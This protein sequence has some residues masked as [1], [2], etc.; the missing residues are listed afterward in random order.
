V[1]LW[2]DQE[3]NPTRSYLTV[4][5]PNES[6]LS[7]EI[8]LVYTVPANFAPPSLNKRVAPRPSPVG[9]KPLPKIGENDYVDLTAVIADPAARQRIAALPNPFHGLA[10]PQ[11]WKISFNRV[12]GVQKPSPGLAG[13]GKLTRDRVALDP[14][15]VLW[16]TNIAN[17]LGMP[18][19]PPPAKPSP[20]VDHTLDPSVLKPH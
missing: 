6:G 5:L 3:P 11:V 9:P 7:G 18:P 4:G 12:V 15:K 13:K 2:K 10:R 20:K 19:A 1:Q 17:A 16:H 8:T 14:V